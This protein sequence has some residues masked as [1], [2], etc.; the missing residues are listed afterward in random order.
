[1]GKN[2]IG[3]EALSGD[4]FM[5]TAKLS[6]L[7]LICLIAGCANIQP[8]RTTVNHDND[9]LASCFTRN[10][11][12]TA[13]WGEPVTMERFSDTGEVR[14]IS[15]LHFQWATSQEIWQMDFFPLPDDRS[16]ITLKSSFKPNDLHKEH[17][18]EIFREC[19]TSEA[20]I[21]AN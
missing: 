15:T 18:D 16:A 20:Q 2:R 3:V 4:A 7:V 8:Q 9:K 14:A 10:A 12:D 5:N 19:G 1:M 21:G 11:Q 6:L 17:S 13:F